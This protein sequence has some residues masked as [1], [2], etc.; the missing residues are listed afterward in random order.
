MT[1]FDLLASKDFLAPD[2]NLQVYLA[3][4]EKQYLLATSVNAAWRFVRPYVIDADAPPGGCLSDN[5][6]RV[7]HRVCLEEA[8]TRSY[9]LFNIGQGQ[10]RDSL[11]NDQA[12]ATA[13][14]G[15]YMFDNTGSQTLNFTKKCVVRSSLMMDRNNLADAVD[16][17]DLSP[18]APR[19][20]G[21]AWSC[22]GWIPF[23]GP[24]IRRKRST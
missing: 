6:G 3:E 23:T 5:R 2:P 9:W 16:Q 14:S 11:K 7:E 19:S 10:E 8:P 15:W 1:I 24:V 18:L 4:R 12:Q 17:S 13:P 21:K 22:L 20:K